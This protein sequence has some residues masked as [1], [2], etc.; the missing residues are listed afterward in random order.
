VFFFIV[1]SPNPVVGNCVVA[2]FSP[3]LRA[4]PPVAHEEHDYSMDLRVSNWICPR[5]RGWVSSSG[6]IRVLARQRHRAHDDYGMITAIKKAAAGVSTAAPK[7]REET[8]M[9]ASDKTNTT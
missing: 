2:L 1:A 6:F 7:S 3:R 4:A 5:Q 8:P 9:E